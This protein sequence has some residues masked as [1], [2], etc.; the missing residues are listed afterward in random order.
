MLGEGSFGDVFLGILNEAGAHRLVALKR[1]KL[2]DELRSSPERRTQRLHEERE[3]LR[4]ELKIMTHIG[5][6]PNVVQLLGA[7]TKSRDDFC[8]IL[9]YCELGSLE[10][11]L[12]MKFT[13]DLFIDELVREEEVDA[14]CHCFSMKEYFKM[15]I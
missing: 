10:V 9:E 11:F 6:H 13:L 15:N 1:P 12:Q 2:H 14:D 8:I 3:C 5:E 4:D 7:I